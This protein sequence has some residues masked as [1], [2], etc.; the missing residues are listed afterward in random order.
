MTNKRITVYYGDGYW[1]TH[2]GWVYWMRIDDGIA[3]Y[4]ILENGEHR[5]IT[6][7]DD[8]SNFYVEETILD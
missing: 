6:R 1:D 4:R 7:Y 3:V 8:D 2:E 5:H